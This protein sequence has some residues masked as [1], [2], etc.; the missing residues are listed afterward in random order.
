M[1]SQPSTTE[2]VATGRDD[3]GSS[4]GFNAL[5]GGIA[6]V[7]LS[8]IPLSTLLGGA[9]AG[10][11]EGG[12]TNAGIRV[13]AYAGLI[14]LVPF[15]F[16]FSAIMLFVMGGAPAAF[17]LVVVFM[18]VFGALYTVGLSILGGVLGVYIKNE[19]A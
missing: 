3:G 16:L 6:G 11:L 19:I 15:V 10:Y 2:T 17:W 7:L 4:T 14:M 5:I 18:F 1:A 9:V 8:F 13:G 12:T